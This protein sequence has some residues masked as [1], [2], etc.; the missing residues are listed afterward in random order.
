VA[1]ALLK[2]GGLD[3]NTASN[4]LLALPMIHD[5]DYDLILMDVQMP[6]MD[7]LEATRIIRATPALQDLP[8]LAMTANVFPEDRQACLGAGMNDFIAKPVDVDNLF[9][10]LAKWLP[11][12][13]A[14]NTGSEPESTDSSNKSVDEKTVSDNH[15]ENIEEHTGNTYDPGSDGAIDPQ[16]LEAIFGNDRQAK[17]DIL[18]KFVSQANGV[19]KRIEE[20]YV[21]LSAERVSFH[22]HKLKS[23]ARTVGANSLSDLCFDLE[24]AGRKEDW[25]TIDRLSAQMGP[26]ME[27][28]QTSLKKM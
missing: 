20:A 24:V 26:C 17:L 13:V 5:S 9:S 8:I 14:P 7:G 12:E 27:Q 1:I 28:V 10:I 11:G 21:Q 16:A 25:V 22:A 15:F 3:A 18:N 23:S 6:V 19:H 2:S 4:G